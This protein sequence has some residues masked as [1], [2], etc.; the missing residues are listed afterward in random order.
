MKILWKNCLYFSGD[1][2]SMVDFGLEFK[3]NWRQEMRRKVMFCT[4]P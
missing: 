3:I 2:E 4:V 1:S